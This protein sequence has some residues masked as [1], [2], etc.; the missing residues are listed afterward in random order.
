MTTENRP[1]ISGTVIYVCVAL[2]KWQIIG[3]EPIRAAI[4]DRNTQEVANCGS[5][6]AVFGRR[7]LTGY[8][9]M[10]VANVVRNGDGR[11]EKSC[12]TNIGEAGNVRRRP[13]LSYVQIGIAAPALGQVRSVGDSFKNH[14]CLLLQDFMSIFHERIWVSSYHLGRKSSCMINPSSSF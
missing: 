5:R 6:S 9:K 14:N 1:F 7:W 8:R 11:R 2:V 10:I 3:S 13:D 12:I 4:D